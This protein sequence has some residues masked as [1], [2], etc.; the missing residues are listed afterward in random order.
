MWPASAITPATAALRRTF[1][2][3]SASV[4]PRSVLSD[5]RSWSPSTVATEKPRSNRR[6]TTPRAKVDLPAPER[7]VS[8]TIA[9]RWWLRRSRSGSVTAPASARAGAA[10]AA[11][12]LGGEA[13][14]HDPVAAQQHA[15]R[16]VRVVVAPVEHYRRRRAHAAAARCCAAPLRWSTLRAR[17]RS[18]RSHGVP[19]TTTGTSCVPRLRRSRSPADGPSWSS[20]NVSSARSRATTGASCGRRRCRPARRSGRRRARR[21]SSR[22]PRRAATSPSGQ[23]TSR[24]ARD[25]YAGRQQQQLAAGVQLAAGQRADR[26]AR[27]VAAVHVLH[28][29]AERRST[30]AGTRRIASI[31]LDDGRARVPGRR[32]GAGRD[33]GAEGGADRHDRRRR[34]ALERRAQLAL[35]LRDALLRVVEQV[36]LVHRDDDVL[37]AQERQQVGVAQRLLADARDGVDHQYRGVGF[38]RAAEHVGQELA[39]AGR[40]DDHVAPAVVGEPQPGG[41]D[42]DRLVALFLQRVEHVRPLGRRAAAGAA[43][44]H[45]VDL[46][47]VQQAEVVQQPADQGRLAVVDVAR[48]DDARDLVVGDGA[49]RRQRT[50]RECARPS[51]MYPAVRRRSKESSLSLSITRPAR[52]GSRVAISS[53]MI[54]STVAASLLIGTVMFF[55]PSDR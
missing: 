14:R 47:L 23:R 3:R 7:P 42:R 50:G 33:V 34:R 38:A 2:A 39:V 4:K 9:A 28:R 30:G 40:V 27:A 53:A 13:D 43:G 15:A 24:S 49:G 46:R 37:D 25:P 41:V 5:Q 51:Y 48:H 19:S 16:A 54:A 26:D 31:A 45:V 29:Q 36:D 35:Q 10:L 18:R 1:S 21:R 52:S 32:L 20:Q 12:A 44:H 11:T 8:Q 17:R 6:R 55:S 22:R